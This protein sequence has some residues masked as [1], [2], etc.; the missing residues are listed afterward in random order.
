MNADYNF[1][2]SQPGGTQPHEFEFNLSK[3]DHVEQKSQITID[4]QTYSIIPKNPE[5][6]G[7][8]KSILEKSIS[9]NSI[10]TIGDLKRHITLA[11]SSTNPNTSQ[12]NS[13]E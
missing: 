3:S 7:A 9:E 11:S 2:F 5:D 6:L 1:K 12:V 8:I 10:Q 13:E 4:E